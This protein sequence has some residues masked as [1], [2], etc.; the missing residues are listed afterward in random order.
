[1]QLLI[2]I[3]ALVGP[4]PTIWATSVTTIVNTTHGPVIGNPRNPNTSVLSFLS[5]PYAAPP[6][7]PL[8]WSA[9]R[10]PQPWTTPLDTTSFGPSCWGFSPG[11]TPG[12]QSGDCLTV[13]VWT[14]A[15]H[16]SEKRP[17]MV[18]IHGGGCQFGATSDPTYDGSSFAARGVVL[19]SINYRLGALGS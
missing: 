5:I 15:K 12:P 3:L 16:K 19:V 9:P 13:S 10:F 6:I 8:R 2:A 4:L 1:M 18:F 7:G 17:V 11:F 14:A